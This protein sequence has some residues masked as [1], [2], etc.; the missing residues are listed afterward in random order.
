VNDDELRE[1]YA[2]VRTIA[3][4][5]ASTDETKSA[6]TVPAY[7]QAQGYRVVPVNPQA[8]EI[9]GEPAVASLDEVEG[10][11]DVVLVFRPGEEAPAIAEQAA[12]MGARVLWLQEGI[13]SLE[14]QRTGLAAGMVVVM[15]A[16]MRATH[17]RL[18]LERP[19]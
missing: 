8:D 6:N 15:D 7:L 16:C 9:I 13:V 5:G 12:V 2:T 3:V 17:R 19:E 4:V 11:V 18:G 1:M 14:A 10:P